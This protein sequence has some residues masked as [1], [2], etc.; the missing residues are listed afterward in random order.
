MKKTV[1]FLIITSWMLA[2][3]NAVAQQRPDP[4]SPPDF[5]P[6][7][8][9]TSKE[10][11]PFPSSIDNR[12]ILIY[13]PLKNEIILS[14]HSKSNYGF[15]LQSSTDLI[16]WTDTDLRILGNENIIIFRVAV[17]E[18]IKNLFFRITFE[19]LGG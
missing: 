10:I 13:N 2:S 16:N 18:N 14:L 6:E 9:P 19:R 4:G 3:I 15:I 1:H 5:I 12:A 11:V 7:A 8:P 17:L